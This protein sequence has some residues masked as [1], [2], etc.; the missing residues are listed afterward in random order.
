ML[1]VRQ[2]QH[3]FTNNAEVSPNLTVAPIGLSP[4]NLGLVNARSIRNKTYPLI[5]NAID[6]YILPG[7][8]IDTLQT[9]NSAIKYRIRPYMPKP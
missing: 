4:V 7:G 6:V 5:D 9:A 2:L 8:A 1:L 3:G